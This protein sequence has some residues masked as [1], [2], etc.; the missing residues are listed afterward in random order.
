MARVIMKYGIGNKCGAINNSQKEKFV[1][2]TP[3]NII[4]EFLDT[5]TGEI[6]DSGTVVRR[7][8]KPRFFWSNH[9]GCKMLAKMNLSKNEY[10][11]ILM[12]QSK[13]GYKNLLFVN[14]TKLAE[15]FEC[16]RVMVSSTISRL[17]KKGLIIKAGTGYRFNDKYVKCGE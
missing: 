5:N 14:K 6:K 12:L 8:R 4:R 13:V 2:P 7:D 1:T 17:E 11:V 9:E 16:G 3:E 10:R 15:E